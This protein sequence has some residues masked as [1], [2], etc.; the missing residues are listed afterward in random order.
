MAHRKEGGRPLKFATVAILQKAI[1][2]YFESCWTQKYDMFGNLQYLKTKDEDGKI[3]KVPI[4][5]QTRPYTITGLA[6]ALDTSR[7]TLL[8]YENKAEFFDTIKRAKQ[9]CHNY[10]EE[11]LF[12]GKA[13]GPIFALKNNYGWIDE[14]TTNHSGLNL[15]E[16]L[17]QNKQ[18]KQS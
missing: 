7:E 9:R 17:N 6:V 14:Q 1:D 16:L 10:A 4:M 12:H 18:R 5:I 11:S 8:H 2:A 13:T 15:A 3:K